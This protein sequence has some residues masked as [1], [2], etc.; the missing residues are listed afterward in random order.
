MT[1]DAGQQITGNIDL[2]K[3]ERVLVVKLRSIGDTVL[4]TPSL[5]AL[6]RALPHAQIDILLE[7]WV[8]PVLSGFGEVNEILAVKSG[9]ADRLRTVRDLRRRRYDVAFNQHGGTTATFFT[10]ASGAKHRVGFSHYQYSFLYN[11]VA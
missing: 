1:S 2:N 7:D 9:I 11:H 10:A 6:R 8:A 5:I 3:V 4:T